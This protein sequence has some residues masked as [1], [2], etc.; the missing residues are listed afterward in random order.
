MQLPLIGGGD[1]DWSTI[2]GRWN[3]LA[4]DTRIAGAL[5][6]L[7]WVGICALCGWV[8]WRAWQDR[9]RSIPAPDVIR[10]F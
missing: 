8:V 9:H 4:Y 10:A 5:R 3:L 7:G 1:H 6:L 2:L